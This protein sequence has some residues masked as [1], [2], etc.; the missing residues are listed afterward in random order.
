M[1]DDFAPPLLTS[2]LLPELPDSEREKLQAAVTELFHRQAI[3]RDLPG[4]RDLY[5]WARTHFGWVREICALIGFEIFI[6]EDDQLIHALPGERATLRRLRVEW[7]LVLLGLWYDYDVRLRAEGAPVVLTVEAFNESLK[8][9]L[10]ERMP[11]FTTLREIL[12]FAASHKLVRMDYDE[13]FS[14]SKIEVLPTIRFVLP[15][16]EYEKVALALDDL[17]ARGAEAGE[18]SHG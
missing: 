1:S 15:F 7:T 9:K 10:G 18:E 12:S 17:M 5:D 3:V 8:T 16:G 2:Q 11:A 13:E 14:K 6:S 4:D